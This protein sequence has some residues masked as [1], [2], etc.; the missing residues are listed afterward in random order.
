MPFSSLHAFLRLGFPHIVFSE[1]ELVLISLE[2]LE[3]LLLE[4]LELDGEWYRE[5]ERRRREELSLLH[6][7]N[8]LPR[9]RQIGR[10]PP[11]PS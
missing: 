5:L 9:K 7:V 8:I 3:L 2:L 6:N 1:D 4:L 10:R 11:A